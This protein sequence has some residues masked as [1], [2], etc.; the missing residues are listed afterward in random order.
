M[1]FRGFARLIFGY[2]TQDQFS[3]QKSAQVANC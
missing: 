2:R 1:K 3:F